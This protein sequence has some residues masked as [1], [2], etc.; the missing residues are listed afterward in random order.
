MKV[1]RVRVRKSVGMSGSLVIAGDCVKTSLLPPCLVRSER[2][3]RNTAE[4]VVAMSGS[5]LRGVK[6]AKSIL[7]RAGLGTVESR[8]GQLCKNYLATCV[9]CNK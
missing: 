5:R 1:D 2:S 7:L 4:K 3:S 8:S 9:S 6:R